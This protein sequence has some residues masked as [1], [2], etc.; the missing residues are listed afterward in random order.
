MAYEDLVQWMFNLERFGIK[1]GLGNM[2]EFMSRI[3][4]PHRDFKS[5]HVTGTNGKGSVC[6]FLASMLTD[7]GMKI[8]LYTSPHLVDFR[9][10]VRVNGTMISEADVVRIGK[11]LR[12]TME[13][14]A[15]EDSE[16]QLTFFEL[17]TGL[18]FRYFS[19]IEVDLAIVEVGMGGRLDATNLV[20]P[21]A[22]GI[23]RVGL[24]H[25]AYLG[26]TLRDIAREKAGIIKQGVPVLSCESNRDVLSILQA[27]CDKKA[28]EL[29][30]L[31]RDFAFENGRSTIDGAEFDYIGKHSIKKLRIPLLGEH[32]MENA[33]M[34]V[35][36]AEELSRKGH[37]IPEDCVR[38][39]LSK[40]E[41][42]GRLD[43]W[44]RSP[45]VVLDGSHNPEGVE[46]SVRV[47]SEQGL[48]PL[49][50]V[51]ACM[52]DKDASGILRAL[53]GT[54]ERMILTQV[55][56][57][58]SMK[59]ADLLELAKTEFSG[60]TEA[61]THPDEAIRTA[62]SSVG[63]KGVCIIG[64]FYLVGAAIRWLEGNRQA[65]G[66]LAATHKV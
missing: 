38:S 53:S 65:E 16:K 33:T 3:G 45:L 56:N 55:D 43:F 28:A 18:A 66:E 26:K 5:V 2:T 62:L 42:R 6:A 20:N 27:S 21:E 61:V 47:L 22:V 24:E 17:T 32:Q 25:T 64:S 29:R 39:G 57:A 40:T 1:L 11:E 50:Y 19:E 15:M 41:W 54:A 35:A 12:E 10:R 60:R 31:G 46:T 7:A 36:I 37:D 58:R 48:T 52:N 59:A 51:L 63:G 8:G 23:T 4:D 44:S 14:M 13:S 9:E 49:T 34:A 30:L